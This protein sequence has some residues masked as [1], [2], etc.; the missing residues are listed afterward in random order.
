MRAVG[1][2]PDPLHLDGSSSAVPPPI[3]SPMVQPSGGGPLPLGAIME[4]RE[5]E[6]EGEAGEDRRGA[7]AWGG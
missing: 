7:E 6:G 5:D 4:D 1:L 2:L 3:V